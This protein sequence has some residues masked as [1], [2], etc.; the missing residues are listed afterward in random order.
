M[1]VRPA[2]SAAGTDAPEL[3]APAAARARTLLRV[4][5]ITL[6]GAALL[7]TVILFTYA[8]AAARV[9]EHR[10]T[11]ETLVHAETGLDVRFSELR[12]RWGWY[13]PEAVF[14]SIELHEPGAA[15]ALLAAPQL[16]LGVDL[17]R[18]LRSGD[19]AISRVTLV[20]P[21]IDLTPGPSV[22]AAHSAHSALTVAPASPTRLLARWRGTRIDIQGGTLRADLAGVPLDAG[23]RRIELRRAGAEWTADALLALPE[24][25]GTTFEAALR[26]HGDGAQAADLTGT[27]TLSSHR[28][29]LSGWGPLL[30]SAPLAQYLP[31]AG[32]ADL[33]VQLDLARGE[34]QRAQGTIAGAV[35]EWP[36][37]GPAAGLTLDELHAEWQLLRNRAGWHLGVEPLELGAG[38]PR[39]SLSID[40]ASDGGWVRGRLR[41]APAEVLAG[42]ARGALPPLRV[43]GVE[44]KGMVREASFDWSTAR[45]PEARLETTA[46]VDELS[47]TPA[48]HAVTLAGLTAHLRGSG[49]SFEAALDAASAHATFAA[50]PA[51]VPG[52]VGVRARLALTDDGRAWRINTREL[53][54]HQGNA[55]LAVTG[56]LMGEDFG[57][58]PRV[59]A[60]ATLSAVPVELVREALGAPALAALGTAAAEV[61][62]GRIEHAQLIARGPLD[63]PL[64]WSGARRE[65]AGTLRLTGA[66]LAALEDWPELNALDAR[67]DWRGARVRVRVDG[68]AA[69]GFQ[70]TAA[71]A[72][73]DARDA[74]LTHLAGRLTGNAADALAWLRDHPRLEPYAPGID[75]IALS[76]G[77]VLDFELRR[78]GAAHAPRFATRLSARIDG[79]Q[80]RPLAG[81]P[82]I[83]AL[84]GTLA[85]ADGRLQR[86]TLTGQWLGGPIALSVGERRD[87]GA[88]AVAISGKGVLDVR[89]AVAAATG[90]PAAVTPLQGNAEWSADL[91]L[92]PGTNGVRPGWRVRADTSLAGVASSLPEPFA[93]VPGSVL[94]L[95]VEL[96]GTED[97]GELRVGLGE[98]LRGLAAVSRRGQLWRIERGAVSFA[99]GAPAMPA[100]PVMQI[101]GTVSRLDL[102]GY[103]LL[104]RQLARNSALPA[105]RIE[106]TAAELLAADQSFA[107]VH[108]SAEAGLASGQVRLESRDLD[109]RVDWPAVVDAAHPVSAHL[110]RLDLAQLSGSGAACAA[111]LAALGS[112]AQ[113]S[114]GDLQ[115]E[116]RPLG[117]LDATLARHGGALELQGLHITGAGDEAHGALKCRDGACR[118]SFNLASHG[119]AATLARLG[120]RADLSAARAWAS[121][122]LEWPTAPAA[123][124][125]D[126]RGQLHVEL[127]D[128]LARSVA[129][130]GAQGSPLGLLAVPALIAGLGLPQLP[131]VRLSADFRIAD[132][133]ATTSNLHL[134]GETEILMRGRIGLLAHDYDAQVWVLKGEERLPATVRHLA[135]GPSVAALWMSLRE[136][137]TG[138]NHERAAL[139]LRGTWDDP[140]VSP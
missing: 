26:L 25:L 78:A 117:G 8:L 137:F 116:G 51:L 9:P 129:A 57:D 20:D 12:L 2:D 139:R 87:H 30:K 39:A 140:M 46:E 120:F 5:L 118:A 41:R 114:I 34:V 36:A 125:A 70:L 90:L 31:A 49:A 15:R 80:L 7:A 22:R 82:G 106:L 91:R 105:L 97:A 113:L 40:A 10:A 4:L 104:W 81:L 66:S 55:R 121:G 52:P 54:I 135:P 138:A 27:L 23:I 75:G 50:D 107:D 71:R 134:D 123:T 85:F 65:F 42:L 53:E 76:G 128:G 133:E 73:W 29:Q 16:V 99:A 101:E 108:V 48:G 56:A 83:E 109:A 32:S 103:A 88:T 102:P 13:G 112:D 95:H 45:P 24:A 68:A 19:L 89:Q 17:W 28:L 74:T 131:F 84:R 14:Q 126:A 98:R 79:A 122:E 127:D 124:L 94:P 1:R 92:A 77:T 61:T 59:D 58:H 69:A 64:P 86:S 110:E 100:A 18:M 115:W 44:L 3:S 21:N 47:V 6:A 93:K 62:G 119:A 60:R 37:V 111:L 72:E 132:G 136:L 33:T 11:L 96:F 63:E 38:S 35:L 67:I 130:A 43:S